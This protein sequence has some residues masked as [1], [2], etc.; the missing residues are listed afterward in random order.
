MEEEVVGGR[1]SEGG[2]TDVSRGD[3]RSF[4][5]SVAMVGSYG[6]G[7]FFGWLRCR[8]TMAG[9]KEGEAILALWLY[10]MIAQKRVE[11]LFVTTLRI[12]ADTVYL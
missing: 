4:W 10:C 3:K 12:G 1:R 8:R 5:I 11:N 6:S 7:L 2:G 9:R